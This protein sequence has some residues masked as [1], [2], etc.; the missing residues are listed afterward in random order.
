MDENAPVKYL[1]WF[2]DISSNG[3]IKIVALKHYWFAY[4]SL[5][6]HNENQ[7]MVSIVLVTYNRADR[8]KLSIQDV[9]N[10]TFKD[11]ELIICDDCSTDE[12]ASICHEFAS[13]DN[14]IRYFRHSSNMQMPANCNF[15]IRQASFEYIAILH[16]GDRFRPDLIEKWYEA[17]STNDSVGFVFNS[18]GVTDEHENVVQSFREFKEGIVEK[19]HLLKNVY[20]RRW[21]FDS[22]VYGEAMV[23]KKLVQEH[24]YLLTEYG[25]YADVNLW[26]DLLHTHDAYYCAEMLITGPMKSIQPQLFESNPIRIFLYMFPM[27]L[28]NRH[29][30]FRKQPLKLIAELMIFWTQ[31]FLNLT[32]CLILIAKNFSFSYFIGVAKL[33]KKSALFLIPWLI[34]LFLYPILY[35]F[36]RMF[37]VVKSNFQ[38]VQMLT[39]SR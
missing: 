32:Y 13:R 16:D 18:I 3:C 22:P 24:G 33:L 1:T 27:Q 9:L 37:S 25:F 31:S 39:T 30:A 34:I 35:P 4:Y 15:G 6:F 23:R 20:F 2:I 26:M 8:L 38:K 14:R 7:T 21:R 17:L 11:F 28:K 19:D 12:T 36:L 10:Q 29:K 5:F